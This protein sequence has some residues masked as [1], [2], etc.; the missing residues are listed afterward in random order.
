[1]RPSR[2]ATA[3]ILAACTG[4]VGDATPAR[5]RDPD[6]IYVPGEPAPPVFECDP[7]A[8]PE[9]LPL[10]RLSRL[11]L[12][13]TLRFAIRSALPGE[14]DAIWADASAVFARYPIDQ[15]V[16]APG[17]LKGG[18]A[19]GD[20]SIR[21][22][23][24]DAMYETAEAIAAALTA[25]SDRIATML[26]ACAT[27]AS[28]SN[29][30]A[31]LEGFVASW[32]A[33][34]M[35]APLASDDVAFYADAAGDTP[36]EPD[37]LRDVIVAILNAPQTLYRVEHG[38]DSEAVSAL[39]AFELAARLSYAF[40]DSPPDDELWARAEDGSLLDAAVYEGEVARLLQSPEAEASLHEFVA[41]WLRLI[42]LPP[43]DSLDGD[44]AFIA[45][46]GD[47]LPPASA[48]DQM[49]G[50]VGSSFRQVLQTGGSVSD[51]LGDRRS[52]AREDFL[53][54]IYGAPSW[55]GAEP[56]LVES[57]AGLLTRA[58]M[59]S[60]GTVTTRPIHKGYIVRNAIL[61]QE[62][63]APPPDVNTN[64][65][66]PGGASTTREAVTALTAGG[67][68]GACHTTRINPPGFITE[69]FDALGRERTEERSFDEDG[70][71]V[72]S[73][74][75]DTTAVPSLMSGDT[76]EMHDAVELTWA[77]DESRLFHS[78][79]VRHWFRFSHARVESERDE[80]LLADL[81]T[82]ARSGAPLSEVISAIAEARTFKTRRFEP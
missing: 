81:E 21:Q 79:F 20:Q 17:D 10:P 19:R 39:S 15:R 53:A 58:A 5:V 38:T 78:C 63:G 12:E 33:R 69:D 31:C 76:R 1:M 37:A 25:S 80:C 51:F 46:A 73:L 77:I 74:P 16:P 24:I 65:P 35:R 50:D 14:A 49:I 4:T 42:E 56:P 48:R 8:V 28:S 67:L 9:E 40:A 41:E 52:Y 11:Q 27:D 71:L 82:L 59:L 54:G 60:T 55:D 44:P 18:Y 30:R 62:V 45:F 64:P 7:S 13:H 75:I 66:E 68:C 43:L 61:C 32:G 6:P 70:N 3:A 26:G 23:Q 34:V 36:V 22:T 72:A 47:D 2:I 29:D 57:R